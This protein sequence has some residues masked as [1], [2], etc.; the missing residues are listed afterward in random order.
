M[1][2]FIK[3]PLAVALL[4][5][6][7]TLSVSTVYAELAKVKGDKD[8]ESDIGPMGPQGPQGIQG[9]IGLTGAAGAAG[10]GPVG[11]ATGD[12]QWWNGIA[13][14]MIGV[15]AN[16]T[17]LKNCDGIPTWVA[18]QCSFLIGDTGPAGGKV[19]YV[20]DNTGLHGLEAAPIDQ[21]T[22]VWG[23]YPA[24]IVGARGNAVG[25]GAANTAAIVA[26]CSEANT[27]AKIADA[28][29]LNGYTDWYLPS[30]DEL[31][32]LYQQ[33]TVVGGFAGSD[34]WSSTEG[35]SSYAWLQGFNN[36][37]QNGYSKN[38]SLPVRAVRAF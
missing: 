13:W 22:S 1:T 28:Y 30:K 3:K 24:S 33:K 37:Y 35:N 11:T 38:Y 21:A 10:T 15:G 23:C 27:A 34:Y 7:T 16:N 19:F 26:A 20:T 14:V 12:M 36:G 29:A 18:G 32:L 4:L 5:G 2:I 9:I 8:V 17:T 25:T 6:I 31:N